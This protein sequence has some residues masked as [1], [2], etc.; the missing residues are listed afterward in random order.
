MP[1]I[2]G[3]RGVIVLGGVAMLV[4]S[5]AALCAAGDAYEPGL[6]WVRFNGADFTRPWDVGV[7][8]QIA[9]DTGRTIDGYSELWLGR[10][11][12][13][14]DGTVQFSAEAD[15]GL[16]LWIGDQLVISGWGLDRPREGSLSVQAGQLLPVEVRYFQSGGTGHLRLYWSWSGHPRELIP[17]AALWHGREDTKRV[18]AMK[19]GKAN[20]QPRCEDN[21]AIYRPLQRPCPPAAGP[22]R[23]RKG[24]HLFID[25]YLIEQ[26]THIERRV[27]R[28]KRHLD[29]PVVTGRKGKGDNCFQPYLEVIRD[30]KTGRFRI[31]YG[32]PE[33]AGQSHVAHM[34]SEDGINWI[35]PHRVLK[36]PSPIQFGV[37]V[38]DEGPDFA[39]ASKRFKL[40]YYGK[41]GE[42]GLRVAVS[43]DGLNFTPLVDRTL[44]PQN[45]DINNIYRDPIRNRYMA[46]VSFYIPGERWSGN[47]R[48]TMESTSD[49]L[50]TWKRPWLIVTPDDSIEKGETQFYAM[51]G[52]L[53]RGDLLIG[54]VKVLHDDYSADP[55]GPKAGVGWTSLAWTRDGEHWTRDREV[56]FDQHPTKGQWDHAMAWI[57]CQVPV[58]DEVY[59]YYGGYAQGHKINR[60][61]ERQIGLVKMRTD[62]YV[63]RQAGAAPGMLRTPL[64]ILD[65]NQLTLNVDAAN[66]EV[67]AQV[68]DEHG[69][70]IKGLTLADCQPIQAD[71][72]AEQV[73]WRGQL[74]D[75]K[76]KAVRLEFSLRAAGLFAFDVK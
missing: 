18:A 22:I 42:G 13:P 35:R 8:R 33:D 14:V 36:D 37:S 30:P 15:D 24:P 41:G 64:V 75:V 63:A 25:D 28:P 1:M 58:G 45:H 27:N 32:V 76:G 55:D 74:A 51:C 38:I 68:L 12:T 67:R 5:P 71:A 40:G 17:A 60:F 26:T 52:F 59:L 34:E 31:W 62:R 16:E 4:C 49:D 3:N 11:R 46:I 48:V 47:R 65:G 70:P 44:I 72:L 10:I 29:G 61:E 9:M 73:K 57:D 39:D 54:M 20:V 23:L 2:A 53:A 43:P 56:F 50:L 66:G 21:S 19:E 69:Q 6:A 7:D